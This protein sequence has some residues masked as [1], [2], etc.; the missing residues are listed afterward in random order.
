MKRV[1]YSFAVTLATMAFVVAT[2][3]CTEDSSEDMDAE[4]YTRAAAEM[5]STSETSNSY[6][7]VSG[8]GYYEGEY[9]WSKTQSNKSFDFY[10]YDPNFLYSPYGK[11]VA[12]KHYSMKLEATV[13]IDSATNLYYGELTTYPG[14]SQLSFKITSVSSKSMSY[15]VNHV[16]YNG[17]YEL[18]DTLDSKYIYKEAGVIGK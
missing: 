13:V 4:R 10:V 1:F 14:Y 5:T 6:T 8:A 12:W 16:K 9:A 11:Y 3:G 18:G 17:S 2:V 15:E 7:V